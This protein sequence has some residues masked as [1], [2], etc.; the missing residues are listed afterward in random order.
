M[1]M[2]KT[3]DIQLVGRRGDSRVKYSFG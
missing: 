2:V 3:A 1:G